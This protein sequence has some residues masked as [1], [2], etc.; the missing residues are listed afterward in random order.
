VSYD[1]YVELGGASQ[2]DVDEL[3][4]GTHRGSDISD[5]AAR[6]RLLA[7][8][9]ARNESVK[10]YAVSGDGG[11]GG[12]KSLV[13]H[14]QNPRDTEYARE[15]ILPAL[16]KLQA[17]GLNGRITTLGLLPPG[18]W[19]LRFTFTLSKPWISKDDDPSYVSDSVNPVRKDKVFKVP[20]M[21]PAGWKGVLRW[22]AMH[23]RLAQKKD[24][25][26]QKEFAAE[27]F[28]QALL[29]GDEKGEEPGKKK[30]FAAYLDDLRPDARPEYERLLRQYYNLKQDDPL[31]HHKGRLMF[32]PTFFDLIDVEVINP[33]SRR[34]KAGTHPIYLECVPAGAQGT[35]S[36]F[37][38]PF[39]RIGQDEANTYC[40]AAQD[41]QLAAETITA[42]MLTYG[43]SAKRT[44]GYG[45]ADDEIIQG[46]VRTKAGVHDLTGKTLRRLAQEVANVHW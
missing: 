17:L 37:Y 18:S 28:A 5:I 2:K 8:V 1:L 43:F 11:K 13:H 16:K 38:V 10:D 33:H 3:I 34:T 24:S 22:T 44:S 15:L 35:F 45:M 27:R 12:Y 20:V 36:L 21:S 9:A 39:D 4:Q 30:D 25:L 6:I 46:E 26:N 29:F 41:L 7:G 14:R 19:F 32:H 31:L 23:I 40:Q 42:M